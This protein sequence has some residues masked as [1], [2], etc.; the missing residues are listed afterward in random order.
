MTEHLACNTNVEK[1]I[2]MRSN[3]EQRTG[4]KV[5][6]TQKDEKLVFQKNV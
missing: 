5:Q 3:S 2:K 1:P 6:K 4:R